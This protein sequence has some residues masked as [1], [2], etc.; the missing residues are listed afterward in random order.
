[1]AAP[2]VETLLAKGL[3]GDKRSVSRLISAVERGGQEAQDVL[4]KLWPH[5]GK[6]KIIGVTGPPGAGKSTMTDKL[7]IV[8]ENF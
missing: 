1:M 3:Q 4:A 2:D 5:T 7:E 8:I 6:A